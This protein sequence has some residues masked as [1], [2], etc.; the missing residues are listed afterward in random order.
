[1]DKRFYPMMGAY[2]RNASLKNSRRTQNFRS[3][4]PFDGYDESA[5]TADNDSMIKSLCDKHCKVSAEKN[6]E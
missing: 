5:E 4:S 3:G 6:H 2:G 1:M